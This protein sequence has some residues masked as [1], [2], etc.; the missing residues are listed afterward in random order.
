MITAVAVVVPA[1]DEQELLP[2]CLRR[3]RRA[4]DRVEHRVTVRIVVAADSCADTTATIARRAAR[5]DPRVAVVEGS[6]AQAGRARRAGTEHAVAGEVAPAEAI[7]LAST[8]ADSEVPRGWLE[9]HLAAAE[10]GWHAVAGTVRLRTRDTEL[11]NRFAAHYPLPTDRPHPHVHGANLGIRLD[12]YEMAGGWPTASPTGEDQRLWDAVR[13]A[14]RPVWSRATL[15][16]HTSDRRLARAPA[17][18]AARL[19]ELVP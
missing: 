1:R 19:A 3:L 2:A 15:H 4:A 11:A 16:V 6:W 7:W 10:A 5:D 9:D 8:D 18:F 12:A 13:R 14:G 17:G